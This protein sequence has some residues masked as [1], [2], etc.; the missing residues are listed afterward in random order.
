MPSLPPRTT[1]DRLRSHAKDLLRAARAGDP[2]AVAQVRAHSERLILAGAQLAV[3]R[4]YGF[5]GWPRLVAEVQRRAVLDSLDPDRLRALIAGDPGAAVDE[6]RQWVDHP[7]GASP[8]GYLAM[9]PYDTAT[10][11]WRRVSG[12]G[13][14]ARILLAAGALVEGRPGDSET[15]L[16][17][18]ASYGDAEL[19]RALIEAGA[20]V[21]AVAAAHSGGVPGGSAL[22]HAA[23]FGM[24]D[25]LDVLVAAG[26]RVPD[27][28]LGAAAGDISPWSLPAATPTERLL[29]LV[30]A[31]DHQ[32]LDVIDALVA[33]GTPVDATDPVWGRHPLRVAAENGRPD[34]VRRL[35]AHGAD[36]AGM[37]KDG[38]TALDLARL[39]AA[40]HPDD[41]AYADVLALLE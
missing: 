36:P 13:A 12:A 20:D 9:L 6:L 25:V 41:P 37:D 24:T 15:P 26:A 2:D 30:M 33:A 3:A 34:A 11:L 19:A 14:L 38:R 32:R 8:L 10:G 40:H 28:V 4:S 39:G 31:A 1:L 23:V 5:A 21:N 16:I 29:A 17:T 18:A 27:V 7:L 22:Q 35:L